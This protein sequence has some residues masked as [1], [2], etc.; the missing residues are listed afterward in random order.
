MTIKLWCRPSEKRGEDYSYQEIVTGPLAP[1]PTA[2]G[3]TLP[4]EV[5]VAACC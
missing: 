4:G 3:P 5:T 1:V 2:A